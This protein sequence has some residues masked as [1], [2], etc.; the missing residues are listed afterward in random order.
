[1]ESESGL[2]ML[3]EWSYAQ[4]LRAE[5]ISGKMREESVCCSTAG[6]KYCAGLYQLVVVRIC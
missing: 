1:M 6:S 2:E 3:P 4:R 5:S